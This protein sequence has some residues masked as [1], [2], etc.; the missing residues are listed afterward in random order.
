MCLELRERGGTAAEP[1]CGRACVAAPGVRA[2][3]A[4]CKPSF[5]GY[6]AR[7][8]ALAA[9]WL[10]P[11]V[12]SFASSCSLAAEPAPRSILVLDQSDVTSPFYYSIFSGLR[13]TVT[14]DRDAAI[15]LYVE[16]LDL[17]RFAGSDYEASLTS[18]LRTKY[19]HRPPR[20]LV[21]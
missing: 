19:G 6:I 3:R 4:G 2:L 20:V 10:I 21:A 8:V 9:A 7:A 17:S 1:G 15:S 12:G 14:A 13:S 5:A 11:F 16:S 18:H